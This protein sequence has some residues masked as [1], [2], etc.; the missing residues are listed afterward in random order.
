MV[1]TLGV[2]TVMVTPEEEILVTETVT[3]ILILGEAVEMAVVQGIIMET[4]V[5]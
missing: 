1:G 4:V 2:V 5:G 3:A